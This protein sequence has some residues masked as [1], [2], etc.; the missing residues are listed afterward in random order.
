[1]SAFE[2]DWDA[3]TENAY[4]AHRA[5]LDLCCACKDNVVVEGEEYCRDCLEE[6]E[7]EMDALDE[8]AA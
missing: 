3:G 5:I 6:I 8:A 1:M 7:A 4:A 2:V